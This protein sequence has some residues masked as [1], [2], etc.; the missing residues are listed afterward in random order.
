MLCLHF[1]ALYLSY[2][3]LWFQGHSE[4]TKKIQPKRWQMEYE[5]ENKKGL[6][7]MVHL[8]QL[9]ETLQF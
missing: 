8:M 4:L 5:Q 7:L 9:R 1:W 3:D 2:L 6:F